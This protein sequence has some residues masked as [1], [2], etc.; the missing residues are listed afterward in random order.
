MESV[1]FSI[2]GLVIEKT[3]FYKE[4]FI[5]QEF[6]FTYLGIKCEINCWAYTE[7]PDAHKKEYHGY[8]ETWN[9]CAY[10]NLTKA[11]MEKGVFKHNEIT[12]TSLTEESGIY[13]VGI[14]YQHSYNNAVNTDLL[15]VFSELLKEVD[16]MIERLK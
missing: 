2:L 12:Y 13:K 5:I 14:D 1:I 8:G 15:I 6:I 7:K 9:H 4:D 16:E 10:V 11:Q 3:T